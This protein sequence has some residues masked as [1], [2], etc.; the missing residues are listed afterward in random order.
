M[1]SG[2]ESEAIRRRAD[3]QM[4]RIEVE[5]LAKF[6][7]LT[8]ATRF[9]DLLE[10]AGISKTAQE[11]GGPRFNEGGFGA[12]LQVPI[13]DF[14]EVRVR[15]AEQRHMQAVNR[16]TA[17]AVNVRSERDAYR[18]YRS[19]YDICALLSPRRAA[20]AQNHLGRKPAP[21]QCHADRRLC[22]ARR[23]APADRLDNGGN[24]RRAGLWLADVDLG[25]ALTGGTA[26][27][28]ATDLAE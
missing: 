26:E 1:L 13:F 23:G 6:Y 28:S 20:A 25:A 2:V 27:A 4:A 8:K 18:S 7:G 21:L 11:P 15:D 22:T 9:I 3:L 16:L 5:A 19:A 14:G 24:R 17:A 10:V 12:E